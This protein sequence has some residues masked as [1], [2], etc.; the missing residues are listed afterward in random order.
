MLLRQYGGHGLGVGGEGEFASSHEMVI[1]FQKVE[2]GEELLFVRRVVRLSRI[3]DARVEKYRLGGFQALTGNNHTST[4]DQ[5]C[6]CVNPYLVWVR[7]ERH[8]PP[9]FAA[10]DQFLHLQECIF[11]RI[12]P[13]PSLA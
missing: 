6:L 2:D 1:G 12:R 4:S 5:R 3:K 11:E 9:Y 10:C 8:R 13:V 7:D